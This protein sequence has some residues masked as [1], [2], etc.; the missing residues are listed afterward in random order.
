MTA[1]V[2]IIALTCTT[3]AGRDT[4]HAAKTLVPCWF[5]HHARA[6]LR[7]VLQSQISVSYRDLTVNQ[8]FSDH[9]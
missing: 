8:P 7:V 9:F 3:V 2:G 1:V 5:Y 4:H 6:G